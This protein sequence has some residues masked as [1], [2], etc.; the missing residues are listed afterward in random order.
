M[1]DNTVQ[2]WLPR[3]YRLTLAFVSVIL[4]LSA[5]GDSLYD[6]LRYE[7][8]AILQNH[9]YWRLITGHLVHGSWQHVWLNLAGLLLMSALFLN[10]YTVW[11]WI[12]IGLISM[13]TIDL[14][15]LCLMPQLLWYVGLSG[16]LHGIL[17]AGA[18]AWWR[19]GSRPMAAMLAVTVLGKLIWEQWQGA[20]PLS[21]SLNVIVNAHLYGAAGGLIAAAMLQ[22]KYPARRKLP[23]NQT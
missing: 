1:S 14:G 11:Q 4:V 12:C 13:F 9:Q 18:M 5:G 15:L 8:I 21:G 22:I 20:L 10:T 7:R 17:S 23:Q 2:N 16:V 6:L 19:A 3:R